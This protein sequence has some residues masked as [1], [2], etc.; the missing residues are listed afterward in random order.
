MAMSRKHYNALYHAIRDNLVRD[1]LNPKETPQ[2]IIDLEGF[3]LDLL[4]MLE[5]D[6]PGFRAKA[7][8]KGLIP[9]PKFARTILS[10]HSNK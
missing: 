3:L 4:P 2:P 5:S 1:S 6:N 10:K 8:V 7:L 9:G